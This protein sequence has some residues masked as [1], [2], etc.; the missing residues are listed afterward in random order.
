MRDY[1]PPAG[2]RV[3]GDDEV[4]KFEDA[5]SHDWEGLDLKEN[6]LVISYQ[7]GETVGE[8]LKCIRGGGYILTPI[9]PPA[10]PQPIVSQEQQPDDG[11]EIYE[12]VVGEPYSPGTQCKSKSPVSGWQVYEGHRFHKFG[13]YSFDDQYLYRRPKQQPARN[14]LDVHLPEIERK[15]NL[16]AKDRPEILDW[17]RAAKETLAIEAGKRMGGGL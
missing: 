3:K 11:W 12:P 9:V 13:D 7:N 14:P 10:T 2:W 15:I 6:P 17:W 16:A 1:I 5:Y 4:V 8:R